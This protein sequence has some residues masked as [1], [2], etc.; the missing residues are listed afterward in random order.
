MHRLAF[1]ERPEAKLDLLITQLV[2]KS[3]KIGESDGL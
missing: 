2:N 1:P 3:G